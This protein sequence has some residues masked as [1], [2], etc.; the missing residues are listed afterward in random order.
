MPDT[1]SRVVAIGKLNVTFSIPQ[2]KTKYYATE[3]VT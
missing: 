2:P 1:L 3:T